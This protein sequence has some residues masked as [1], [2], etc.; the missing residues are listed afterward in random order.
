[1]SIFNIKKSTAWNYCNPEKPEYSEEL[2]GVIVGMDN[3]QAYQ[4]KTGKKLFWDNGV[5]KRNIRLFV[6]TDN[7]EKSITFTPKS[8]LFNAFAFAGIDS[9]EDLIQHE[10]QI[11]T[12]EGH[13]WRDNPR[14]WSVKVGG[15]VEGVKLHKVPVLDY[16]TMNPVTGKPTEDEEIPF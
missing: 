13:Y 3:P 6:A 1:M 7:G 5:P 14:P 11:V 8:A 10:V 15:I 12:E 4:Y 16:E 2:K 9:F